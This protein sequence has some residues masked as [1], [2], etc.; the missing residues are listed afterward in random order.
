MRAAMIVALLLLSGSTAFAEE[1][2][3]VTCD[4]DT[5]FACLVE[6]PCDTYR[7]NPQGE[8]AP[9]GIQHKVCQDTTAARIHPSR[10]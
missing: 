6:L 7:R 9:M 4:K 8:V 3:T 10:T 5:L 1:E 2:R